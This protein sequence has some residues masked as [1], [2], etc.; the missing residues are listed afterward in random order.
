MYP[1]LLAS[2]SNTPALATASTSTTSTVLSPR[3]SPLVDGATMSPKSRLR[4]SAPV[5][6]SSEKSKKALPG[7]E[8]PTGVE[9][10]I[11]PESKLLSPRQIQLTPRKVTIL[12]EGDSPRQLTPRSPRSP[13]A[14]QDEIIP[15]SR[16]HI[17]RRPSAISDSPTKPLSPQRRDA[18]SRASAPPNMMT[19]IDV[20]FPDQRAAELS[21]DFSLTW[22]MT[23]KAQAAKPKRNTNA[24]STASS[25]ASSSTTSTP[26]QA[27]L[28]EAIIRAFARTDYKIL[29]RELHP[30]LL[31]LLP[32]N[33]NEDTVSHRVILKALFGPALRHSAAGK[34]LLTMKRSVM[35]RH[36]WHAELRID[37]LPDEQTKLS[38]IAAMREQASA[39][40]DMSFGMGNR[41]LAG[42]KLP[43]AL[44][45]FWK[46]MDKQLVAW[47]NENSSLSSELVEAARSNLGIDI[48]FTSMIYP[49]IYGNAEEAHLAVPGWFANAVREAHLQAWPAFFADFVKQVEADNAL[50]NKEKS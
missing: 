17:E 3:K 18:I 46:L 50:S 23:A 29:K 6:I 36:P 31:A 26:I 11:E 30:E 12:D 39:T 49:A 21:Q 34:T 33:G 37:S 43:S 45:E 38:S 7:I 13:R 32:A 19:I 1:N 47:A 9:Q 14:L 28:T 10:K 25:A 35:E 24:V 20:N 2:P 41:T 27:N 44:L 22:I 40:V 15:S 4:A 48:I 16:Q 5:M 8:F 42:S